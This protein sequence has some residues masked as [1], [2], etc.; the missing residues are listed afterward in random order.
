[1]TIPIEKVPSW[2]PAGALSKKVCTF[3]VRTYLTLL[4]MWARSFSGI[5]PSFWAG[6][7]VSCCICFFVLTDAFSYYL[8]GTD[9]VREWLVYWLCWFES[10]GW[11]K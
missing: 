7:K 6:L 9:G 4:N 10:G 8:F 3:E 1:M 11:G 5:V 2:F